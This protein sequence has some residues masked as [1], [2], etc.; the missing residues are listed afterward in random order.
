MAQAMFKSWFID[1]EPFGGKMPDDWREKELGDVVMLSAGGDKPAICSPTLTDK[2]L[3]PVFSN[4]I[5][6]FGLYGYTDRPKVSEE[7]VTVSA[8]G[9]IGFVCLRQ[10]SFVP[11]VRL[12]TAIPDKDFIT[13]KYLYLYLSN[14]H[15]AGVGTT[16][17]QLTVPDFK[18]YRIL[19]P[20]LKAVRNFTNVV[21]PMFNSI[22]HKRA[23]NFR[24]AE[25]RN[26]LL[27][28]LMSGELSVADLGDAK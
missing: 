21:E 16:Q 17:Q 15:I 10:E 8:R 26:K 25:T 4:G 24:L 6:N 11:I 3:V 1:F 22:L 5:D 19:V 12:I 27:P 28:R 23:E 13:A 14:I 9:T 20:S 7:C 18:K 2:C